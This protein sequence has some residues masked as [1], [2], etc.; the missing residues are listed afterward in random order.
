MAQAQRRITESARLGLTKCLL[1]ESCLE[2]LSVPQ[3]MKVIG[4][5]TLRQAI[6]LVLTKDRNR[7]KEE[8]QDS[9]SERETEEELEPV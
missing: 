7:H 1:P 8:H 3:G 4:V 9:E 6:A 2:G 5:K